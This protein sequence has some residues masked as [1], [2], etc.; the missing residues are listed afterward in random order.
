MCVHKLGV[1]QRERIFQAASPLSMEPSWGPDPR[2]HE[3]M[4]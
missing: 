3:I 1:G 4:T 2:T